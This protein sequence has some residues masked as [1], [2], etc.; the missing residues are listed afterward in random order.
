[1]IAIVGEITTEDVAV[2]IAE[3]IALPNTFETV[4]PESVTDTVPAGAVANR[5]AATLAI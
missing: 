5:T 1:M 4:R 3:T 2:E